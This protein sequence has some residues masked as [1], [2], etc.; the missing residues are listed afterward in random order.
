MTSYD[1]VAP[2]QRLSLGLALALAGVAGCNGDKCD[3]DE[4]PGETTNALT[5]TGG[6]DSTTD[7]STTDGADIP[8]GEGIALVLN[9][10]AD[11]LFVIDN[12][13][14]MGEEQQ[15]LSANFGAFVD[16]LED[17][18]VNYRVAVTTSDYG[19]PR[20]TPANFPRPANQGRFALESCRGRIGLDGQARNDF[21]FAPE[22]ID[23]T[24]A[25]T[26]FC[27]QGVHDALQ[28]E[29][30]PTPIE[31][32]G[33]M[34]ARAWIERSNGDYNLPAGVEAAAD[35]LGISPADAAFRCIGPQ[36]INGCGF[37]SQLESMFWA[38]ARAEEPGELNY[39]FLRDAAVLSIVHVTDEADCSFNPAQQNIFLDLNNT[40]AW[41][42]GATSPTSAVCWNAGVDCQGAAP[43]PYASCEVVNKDINGN[44]T[45]DA[46][47]SVLHPLEKYVKQLNDLELEKQQIDQNQEVLVS[48]V[49]GVPP[50][51]DSSQAEIQYIDNTDDPTEQI[52]F[53]IG[54]GCVAA[55]GGS[56]IPPARI[57]DLA[58]QFAVDGERNMFSICD[59]SY[60]N[61]LDAIAR[62]VVDQLKPGCF[63]ICVA[64]TDPETPLVDPSCAVFEESA[65]TNESTELPECALDPD[66]D[67]L[68][69]PPGASACF[70]YRVDKGAETPSAHDDMSPE[71]VEVGWNLE[72]DVIRVEPASPGAYLR[73]VCE[74]SD[75]VERDCPGL[76]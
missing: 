75:L 33:S 76:L 56:A 31:Q 39:G 43:G 54:P 69:P 47:A 52:K 60:A 53:G 27:D 37:E 65:L 68:A 50:G 49:G 55:D 44:I 13:G 22:M 12:S 10:D 62:R 9:K 70:V 72:F 18:G 7:G 59:S 26:D 15:R 16:V 58:E 3:D 17:A 20:C 32:D 24:S 71:C 48:L 64:D 30:S 28:G 36:G 41:E 46:A 1:V 73:A 2:L 29:W 23:A 21:V 5:T 45:G 38:L 40:W 63:P 51:Y 74:L 14:S 8:D 25:C 61:T 57:R 6:S 66:T 19:N 34:E 67:E 11:L 35:G 42:E 4:C